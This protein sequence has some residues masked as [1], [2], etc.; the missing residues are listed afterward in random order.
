MIYRT[1]KN[2]IKVSFR[3]QYALVVL[4]VNNS[5][6]YDKNILAFAT[7]LLTGRFLSL[8]HS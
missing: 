2:E 3:I 4:T 8:F 5:F 7:Y 1:L 6:W